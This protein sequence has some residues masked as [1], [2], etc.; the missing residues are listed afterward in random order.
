MSTSIRLFSEIS[1]PQRGG[2]PFW[3]AG[4]LAPRQIGAASGRF[5]EPVFD[6]LTTVEA[7]EALRTDWNDLY[8]RAGATTQPF[9]RFGWLK[10][11]ADMYLG[12]HDRLL[13]V[14]V[15]QNGV[16][17]AALPLVVERI[18]GLRQLSFMGAPVSQYGDAL[19]IEGAERLSLLR[20]AW[21][22]ALDAAKPDLVRLVK[23]REDAA[24]APLLKSVGAIETS[25]EE[26]PF[27]DLGSY[28]SFEAYQKSRSAKYIKNVRRLWRRLDERGAS[29]VAWDLR[30]AAGYDAALAAVTLKRSWLASRGL[31][32]KAFAADRFAQFFASA[33][34]IASLETGVSTSLLTSR[35]EIA[36]ATVTVSDGRRLA[37]HILG[38]SL[39]FE[40]SAVGVLH[41]EALVRHAFA[42]GVETVD[43]L[44]PR[45]EYKDTWADGAVRVSDFAVPISLGGQIYV[46][47][48][49]ALLREHIK[50]VMA[51]LPPIAVRL[52]SRLQRA[53]S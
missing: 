14:T 24:I 35:G 44:A 6:V 2:V 12:Q 32:S 9:Q 33:A 36:N 11:W 5:A 20:Q 8:A 23:V 46:K 3:S 21:G 52:L 15:R 29:A 34:R 42:T 43:F 31:F 16:L 27:I 53:I 1:K 17:V 10:H 19:A 25:F 38:Y 22:R 18:L 50:V 37:L 47:A 40:K 51:E 13:V 7:F 4:S 28:E 45:H 41:T 49:L 39:K 26:A 30:G 48:Y